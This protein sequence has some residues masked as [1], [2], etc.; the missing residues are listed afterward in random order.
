MAYRM[1]CEHADVTAVIVSLAH[2]ASFPASAVDFLY[3]HR[4]P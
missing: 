2:S 4:K 1:A 3:A